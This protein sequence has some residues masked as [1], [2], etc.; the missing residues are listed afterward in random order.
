MVSDF[1]GPEHRPAAIQLLVVPPGREEVPQATLRLNTPVQGSFTGL[2][3]A[4]PRLAR[5]H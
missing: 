4:G 2:V 1:A 3:E 5:T